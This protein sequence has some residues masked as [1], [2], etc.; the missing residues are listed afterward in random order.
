MD[1]SMIIRN[2][3]LTLASGFLLSD[4]FAADDSYRLAI[5]VERN[6]ITIVDANADVEANA[7]AD[8]QTSNAEA[9]V[10]TS[11]VA[12]VLPGPTENDVAIQLQ[13]FEKQTGDW[14]L[15]GEPSLVTALGSAADVEFSRDAADRRADHYTLR[16]TVTSK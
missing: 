16:L 11:I 13:Y 7:S 14:L 5:Q 2:A 8:L 9:A 3:L 6:G 10:E 4:C 1:I 12:R 15:R